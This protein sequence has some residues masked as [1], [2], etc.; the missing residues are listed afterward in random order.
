[1]LSVPD[2]PTLRLYQERLALA[3][4]AHVAVHEPD[5]PWLGAL[6][7]VGL[8]PLA[9]RRAVKPLL[10]SLPLLGRQL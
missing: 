5:A 10:S 7:A 8:V 4:I 9:D 3:G 1:M 6:T 2:E